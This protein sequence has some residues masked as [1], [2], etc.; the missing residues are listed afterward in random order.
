MLSAI[1]G[2]VIGVAVTYYYFI[3]KAKKDENKTED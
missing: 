1:L 2:F 3:M